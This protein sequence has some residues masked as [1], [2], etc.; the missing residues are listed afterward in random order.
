MPGI[1]DKS[2]S[3]VCISYPRA[4]G[5]FKG[6]MLVI[7]SFSESLSIGCD[8]AS[9]HL[10][11]SSVVFRSQPM[12]LLLLRSLFFV[13]LLPLPCSPSFFPPLLSFLSVSFFGFVLGVGFGFFFLAFTS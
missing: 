1:K 6:Y 13:H 3:F 4:F 11:C 9:S 7:E 12:F 8:E 2:E 5:G 10:F